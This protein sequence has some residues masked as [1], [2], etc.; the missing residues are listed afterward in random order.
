MK[1]GARSAGIGLHRAVC[2]KSGIVGTDGTVIQAPTP[3]SEFMEGGQQQPIASGAPLAPPTPF[4]T[5]FRVSNL[6]AAVTVATPLPMSATST[7]PTMPR[8]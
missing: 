7:P 5:M 6:A 3:N 8:P 4:I 1:R 2:V